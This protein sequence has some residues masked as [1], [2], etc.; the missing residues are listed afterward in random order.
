MARPDTSQC[1]HLL[2]LQQE[3][4]KGGI[5]AARQPEQGPQTAVCNQIKSLGRWEVFK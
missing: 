5:K 4:K 1:A 2:R 3:K